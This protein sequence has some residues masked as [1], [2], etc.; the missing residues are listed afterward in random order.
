MLV[1]GLA[2]A[3]RGVF[4]T[5]DPPW[6]TSVGVVWH[7]EGAWVHNARNKALF[8][9]VATRRVEPA[10][11]CA[12]LHRRSNISRSSC[13]ASACARRDWSPSSPA[14]SPCCCSASA[15]AGSPAISP[16]LLAERSARDQLRLRDVQP[17]R[18][19]GG[20]DDG[21]HRRI[22]VLLDAIDGSTASRARW[23]ASGRPRVLHEGG[24]R[25]LSRCAGSCRGSQSGGARAR[26]ASD[27][28]AARCD[29]PR[30]GRLRV[31]RSR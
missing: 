20:A 6:Q 31:S 19:H 2:A 30:C 18:D 8:G 25:V 3:L 1:L 21:A 26:G 24:G 22:L 28:P 29:R 14:C 13:S 4:P 5:A 11:H 17:R 15:S 12:G 9:V 10:L 23:R 7:D 27:R 16:A